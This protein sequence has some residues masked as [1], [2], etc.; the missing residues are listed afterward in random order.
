MTIK[1]AEE[2]ILSEG[3]AV[4]D[5]W[6]WMSGQTMSFASRSIRVLL[7]KTPKEEYRSPVIRKQPWE[8]QMKRTPEEQIVI[9]KKLAEMKG[10]LKIKTNL[11]TD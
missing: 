9:D 5:F 1:Q 8:E 6:E 10:R 3:L 11:K 7:L 4:P 2:K